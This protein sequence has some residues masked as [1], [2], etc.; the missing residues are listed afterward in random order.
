MWE[1][2]KVFLTLIKYQIMNRINVVAS[3]NLYI[4]SYLQLKVYA[5][6][7]QSR[8]SWSGADL[9]YKGYSC[10]STHDRSLGSALISISVL[11][12]VLTT[13]V[14]LRAAPKLYQE[15]AS[16][17]ERGNQWYSFFWAV[18]FMASLCNFYS[19]YEVLGAFITILS[20]DEDVFMS[21]PRIH[22][23]KMVMMCL[24]IFL[25]ILVA[26]RIP[27]SVKFPI[28][29][30]AHCYICYCWFC[31]EQSRSIW[32]QTL[33]LSSL[34]FF[35]QYVALSAS[36]TIMWA[37]IFPI[38]TLAAVAFLAAAVFCVT[39]LIAVLIRNIGQIT[40]R[41]SCRGTFRDSWS[42]MQPLLILIVTLLLAIVNLTFYI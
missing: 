12:V 36:P 23:I 13:I 37:S 34:L 8:S 6:T 15:V 30:I 42:T 17:V 16:N 10:G 25:D 9:Q 38:Q 19:L 40:W 41:G 5:S 7:Q 4:P 27:K 2:S 22:I 29:I 3:W 11:T 1:A 39:V 26:Y 31:S 20:L 21:E 14:L 35:V 24:L 18:S 33:A 28:P 32:I